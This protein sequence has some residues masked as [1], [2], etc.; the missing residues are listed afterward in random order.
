MELYGYIA[1]NEKTKDGFV[2]PLFEKEDKTLCFQ[3]I[4]MDKTIS[5]VTLDLE[6]DI[7]APIRECKKT[8]NVDLKEQVLAYLDDGEVYIGDKYYIY[9]MAKK[10]KSYEK[11]KDSFIELGKEIEK[12]RK[13]D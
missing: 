4:E 9:D 2:M 8:I 11:Y 3:R 13:E 1:L 7:Y 5:L 10:F 12:E 6:R